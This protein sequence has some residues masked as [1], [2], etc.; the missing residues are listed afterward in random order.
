MPP[1]ARK[2]L[3]LVGAH[4]LGRRTLKN[5]LIDLDRERFGT[6]KPCKI[7]RRRKVYFIFL[8]R[9]ITYITNRGI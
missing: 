4:G 1:F 7:R 3:I 9:Y 2:C 6:T 5:R 8:F